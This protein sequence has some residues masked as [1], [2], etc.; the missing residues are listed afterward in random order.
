MANYPAQK[1]K[2]TISKKTKWKQFSLVLLS[3]IVVVILYGLIESFIDDFL[4]NEKFPVP[5]PQRWQLLST[6][7]SIPKF[8]LSSGSKCGYIIQKYSIDDPES[9]ILGDLQKE[10][11]KSGW[12][13]SHGSNGGRA[14]AAIKNAGGNAFIIIENKIIEVHYRKL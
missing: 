11:V 9:K 1:N 14:A 6:E 5:I 10:V 12:N 7:G 13:F 8:C 3:V 2:K 4:G